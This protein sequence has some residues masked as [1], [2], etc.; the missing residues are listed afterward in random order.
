MSGRLWVAAV[1]VGGMVLGMPARA[2]AQLGG[3]T[4]RARDRAAQAAG[5]QST[6]E[7]ARMPGP[8][9]TTAVLD[10]VM[11]GLKAEKVARDNWAA[12]QA[13]QQR[14]RE[15][16]EARQAAMNNR[17][18]CLDRTMRA[19]SNFVK[20]E[21]LQ[22]DAQ[23]AA[24]RG[25]TAKAV[26]AAQQI[27]G[28]IALAQQNAETKCKAPEAAPAPEEQAVAASQE[29]PEAVGAK[30]AKMSATDYAQAKELLYTYLNF[31]QKAGL[32]ADEKRVVDPRKPQ[33][34]DALKGAGLGG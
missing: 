13:R 6:D 26:Q 24:Q 21:K 19:D 1:V 2:E 5:V 16:E 34:K 25:E 7:A 30:A 12:E 11:T 31:P 14:L 22:R 15:Q 4:K 33:I 32:S 23:A 18:E 28:L 29:S 3:L 8:V 17:S 27:Q 20:A 9:L 10:Q